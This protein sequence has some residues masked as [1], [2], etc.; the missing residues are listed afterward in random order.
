[1]PPQPGDQTNETE[2]ECKWEEPTRE[3]E[4]EDDN[5]LI[6]LEWGRLRREFSEYLENERPAIEVIVARHLNLRSN[7]TC[8][9]AE[10]SQWLDQGT[11]N[12]CVPVFVS[13]WRARRV[14][15]RC[16]FPHRLGGSTHDRTH[17]RED[18]L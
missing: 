3:V 9:V 12:L 14:L 15:L 1:M 4:E 13:N 5:M 17:G 16:P 8:R 7:Q 2:E 6:H 18:P 10:R 11:Y